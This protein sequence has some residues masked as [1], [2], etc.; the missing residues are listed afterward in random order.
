MVH[1]KAS[2]RSDALRSSD[3]NDLDLLSFGCVDGGVTATPP[4]IWPD[5][6]IDDQHALRR[7]VARHRCHRQLEVIDGWH[8]ADGTEETDDG[9][10]RPL[11]V[12]SP[13]V[14]LDELDIGETFPGDC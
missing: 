6:T 9:A 14:C 12:E 10:K 11:K 8:V 1:R 7:E 13:H 5:P 2:R 4:C 3:A